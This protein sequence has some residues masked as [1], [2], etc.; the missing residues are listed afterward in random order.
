M[1]DENQIKLKQE[2]RVVFRS[3]YSHHGTP[4]D[5]SRPETDISKL[6]KGAP[7]S[8]ENHMYAAGLQV[9]TITEWS[10]TFLLADLEEET[11]NGE[12]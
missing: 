12:T 7:R 9:R 1:N 6:P 4:D 10:E 2:Y 5:Y 11:S 8:E 3:P